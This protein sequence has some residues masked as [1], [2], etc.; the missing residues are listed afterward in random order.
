MTDRKLGRLLVSGIEL[1]GF[2]GA[3]EEE[4]LRGIRLVVDLDVA[5]PMARAVEK[6]RVEEGV[7]YRE[8]VRTVREINRTRS[9][10]LIE[11]LA[12]ALADGLLT[13]IPG[14]EE[15]SVRVAKPQPPG[16]GKVAW[17]A[18]EVTRR[19]P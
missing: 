19:R 7:D 17:A 16:M 3:T 2:H 10:C 1:F 14:I 11:S 4:R 18:A 8:L 13:G 5:V 12:D 9:Y 6:D 15:I